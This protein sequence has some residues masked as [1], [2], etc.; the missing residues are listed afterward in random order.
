M[1]RPAPTVHPVACA[2]L[3]L[4]RHG[5]SAGNVARQRAWSTGAEVIELGSRDADVELTE[6]GRGQAHALGRFLAALPT[7]R[8]PD[9]VWA[10]PFVRARDTAA[11]ACVAAGLP[12]AS[13]VDERLRDREMGILEGL[14]G[15]GIAAR[16]PAEAARKR[17][18]GKFYHRPPG[19]ESWIDIAL[20][21]RS[22][23]RDLDDEESGR[24]VLVVAHDAVVLAIRYVCE[25]LSE[26]ELLEISRT[27]PVANASLTRLTRSAADGRWS[28]ASYNDTSYL[29]DTSPLQDI[30]SSPI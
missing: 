9:A 26:A 17:S 25:R 18:L 12:L 10:S 20:R 13:R 28:L 8:T 16:F 22:L 24:R 27:T 19:G 1:S 6:L 5:E 11:I 4:V 3:F 29:Q 21:V 15:R 30:A 23:L 2:E 7:E 14:T